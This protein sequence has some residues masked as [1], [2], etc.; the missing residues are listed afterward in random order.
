[1][2]SSIL[3]VD[4]VEKTYGSR[5]VPVRALA[6][7]SLSVRAGE[8]VAVR[9]PSGSGKSSLLNVICGWETPDRGRVSWLGQSVPMGSLGWADL[10]VVPQA[11]G[12]LAE[13][14]VWE[15]VALPCRF[16]AP[17]ARVEPLRTVEWLLD[18][19]GI[20]HLARR[21]PA[22]TSLGEQQRTAVARALVVDPVL[23][24]ADEPTAHQDARWVAVVFG[25]LR[26]AADGG[27]ACLVATHSPEGLAYADRVLD[28]R[29]GRVREGQSS[30]D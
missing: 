9:G 1:L 4:A 2:P 29:D 5:A 24:L 22:E 27:G 23:V 14:S 7:V 16:L 12:L 15:N 26:A 10:A 17:A 11:L 25:A 13:L 8:L 30:P 19:L 6:G 21:G 20:G 18:Q 3:S 28:I